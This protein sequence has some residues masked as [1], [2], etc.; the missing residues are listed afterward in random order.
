M[1]DD[2][3]ARLKF[4]VEKT[5]H[6]TGINNFGEYICKLLTIDALFLNEDRHTHNIAVL[7][8][9][10]GKYELCPI[11]DNGAALLS[12]ITM[13]YP[14]GLDIRDLIKGVKSKTICDNLDEQLVIAESFLGVD[15]KFSF[16]DKDIHEIVEQGTIYSEE[17][18]KRVEEILCLQRRKY[19]YLFV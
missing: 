13:D 16:T 2:Y 17:I 3:K 19:A 10:N 18:R 4:L 8:S 5:E 1:I 9:G 7:M 12:D 15:I 14:L 6:I 11:F